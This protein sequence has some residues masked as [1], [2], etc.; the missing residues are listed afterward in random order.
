[1]HIITLFRLM[2]VAII[3]IIIIINIIIFIHYYINIM[4]IWT[5]GRPIDRRILNPE[6]CLL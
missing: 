3:I 1:L 6:N 5:R 2:R 4:N